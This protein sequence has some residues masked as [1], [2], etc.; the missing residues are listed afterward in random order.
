[1]VFVKPSPTRQ[2]PGGAEL[3]QLPTSYTLGSLCFASLSL[4]LLGSTQLGFTSTSLCFTDV[5]SVPLAVRTSLTLTRRGRFVKRI[6]GNLRIT[7]PE[8]NSTYTPRPE[9]IGITVAR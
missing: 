2:E 9:A 4:T 8:S 1:M 3:L 5:R 7:H 6:E